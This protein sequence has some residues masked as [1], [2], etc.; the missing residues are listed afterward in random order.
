MLSFQNA[1]DIG[2]I[3]TIVANLNI[4]NVIIYLS[5]RVFVWLCEEGEEHQAVIQGEKIYRELI[6]LANREKDPKKKKLYREKAEKIKETY[7]KIDNNRKLV[8]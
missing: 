7:K 5:N 6:N 3:F 4:I 1:I 2:N 8:L